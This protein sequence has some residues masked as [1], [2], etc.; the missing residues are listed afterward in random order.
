VGSASTN[1]TRIPYVAIP[2]LI[3]GVPMIDKVVPLSEKI[4]EILESDNMDAAIDFNELI[5][6]VNESVEE[7]NKRI[8]DR[9]DFLDLSGCDID[10]LCQVKKWI[11]EVFGK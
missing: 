6:A 1:G 2:K 9:I 8:D 7:L 4:E 11:V 10:E 3:L 5:R